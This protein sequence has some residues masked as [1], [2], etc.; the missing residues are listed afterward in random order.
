MAKETAQQKRR[1]FRFSDKMK[2][3]VFK[4]LIRYFAP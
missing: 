1:F 3:S 2:I 4:T